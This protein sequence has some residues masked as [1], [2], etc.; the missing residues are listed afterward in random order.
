LAVAT[1]LLVLG[2]SVALAAPESTRNE[3]QPELDVFVRLDPQWRLF[4]HGSLTRA[5]ETGTATE[6]T[7]GVHVDWFPH[8]L[9]E[10]LEE[11]F[12]SMGKTW[13]IWMRAGYNRI[14][15]F[16]DD[17]KDEDRVVLEATLRSHPLWGG[18]KLANRNRVDLRRIGGDDSWRYRNRSR[19]ERTWSLRAPVEAGASPLLPAG[20][21]TAAT[22]YAMAE[23]FWDSREA[24]WTR[25][26]LQA[27]VEFDMRAERS[28]ELYVARQND[29]RTAGSRMTIFGLV[30]TLRY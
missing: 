26:Y 17:A 11:L 25:T 10:R 16:G 24:A 14:E 27:G 29:V 12:P 21:F 2:Q 18:L 1:W 6:G 8:G 9:P 5:V 4:A 22:P 7:L 19:V 28:F 15:A 30:Y 20:A 23:F 13:S 3:A